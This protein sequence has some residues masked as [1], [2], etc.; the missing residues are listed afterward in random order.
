[1][2]G[3]PWGERSIGRAIETNMPEGEECRYPSAGFVPFFARC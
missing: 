2:I 3:N 1:M